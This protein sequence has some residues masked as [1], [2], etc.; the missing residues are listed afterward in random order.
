MTPLVAG[1]LVRRND[2]DRDLALTWLDWNPSP[3]DHDMGI[4]RDVLVKKSG[5]VA[6]R[7]TRALPKL[8]DSLAI[9]LL[10]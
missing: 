9:G 6:V 8:D 4:W 5:P 7:G 2:L 1:R 3:P 10:P